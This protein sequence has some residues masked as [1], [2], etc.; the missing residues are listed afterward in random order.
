MK[1]NLIQPTGEIC[2]KFN[3][4]IIQNTDCNS[5]MTLAVMTERATAILDLLSIHISVRDIT[6]QAAIDCVR[7]ELLDIDAYL[8]VIPEF[9]TI[10]NPR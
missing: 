9:Q 4:R 7:N 10:K 2:P 5:L 3:H 8:R 1:N 6:A